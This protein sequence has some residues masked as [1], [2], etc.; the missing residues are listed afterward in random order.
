MWLRRLVPLALLAA[1]LLVAAFLAGPWLIGRVAQSRLRSLAAARGLEAGWDRAEGAWPAAVRF[2]RLTVRRAASGDTLLA[3]DSLAVAIDPGS[4][5]SLHP[6][7]A[8][9]HMAGARLQLLSSHAETDTLVPEEEAQP[10]AD[11]GAARRSAQ[12]LARLLSFQPR[13]LPR[14]DLR[15]ITVVTPPDADLLWSGAHIE[16]LNLVPGQG[17][18]RLESAGSLLGENETPFTASLLYSRDDRLRGLARIGIAA[19]EG[20]AQDLE[21]R[22]DGAL[23]QSPRAVVLH[24][25]THIWVGE[26]PVTLGARVDKDGPRVRLHLA[27][28]GLTDRGVKSS[29]PAALLGP[30][31]EVGVRG[32]WDDLLDFDLDLAHPDSVQ[33]H[34]EVVPH[35]LALDPSRTRLRLLGLDQP[36]V[37]EIHLPK[38]RS[39]TRD[40]SPDNPYFRPL[41][42]I[43]SPLISAV[44][45]NEDGQFFRHRGFNLEA[46]RNSITENVQA[47]AFRRGAGT[48]T[49]QLVRNLYLGH[50]RTL[51]RKLHEVVLAWLLEH[52]TG[53]SKERILEIYL[54]IIEWGPG[55]HGAGEA[56]HYYF[57]RDPAELTVDEA[58]FLATVVPAPLKWRYRF[59]AMGR[60]RPFERAQMHFIGRAMVRKGWLAPEEL[61]PV[62]SLQVELRGPARLELPPPPG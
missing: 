21:L 57:D 24:D 9:V 19:S 11:Q 56:A 62:D 43:C 54:N 49:M 10:R 45:T 7:V 6:R 18:V 2:R 46:V 34:A 15:D 22:V 3:A 13:R 28:T 38:N 50:Q 23:T 35:G 33:L 47:G 5:L 53:L 58:L 12:A 25:S 27:A 31:L 36:F 20:A 42:A 16:Q 32:S 14:L 17:D 41:F 55:I 1:F 39:T 29:L 51:S 44:V 40:L 26:I 48:I 4:L 59:D 30:L 37:A 8:A 61:P 60:L 52:E